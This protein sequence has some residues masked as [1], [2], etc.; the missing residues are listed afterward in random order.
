M[1]ALGAVGSGAMAGALA[2]AGPQLINGTFDELA[3]FEQ[4][5]EEMLVLVPQF[6]EELTLAAAAFRL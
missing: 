2:A 5:I 6:A 4:A 1:I 3:N